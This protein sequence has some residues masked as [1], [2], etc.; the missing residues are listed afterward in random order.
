MDVE[1]LP[2][3]IEVSQVSGN[4]VVTLSG[5]AEGASIEELGKALA[6]VHEQ[7][8]GSAREVVVDLRALE[9]AT[10]S[11]IKAFVTWLQ[12]IHELEPEVRYLAVFVSTKRHPWQE[13]SL[14]ALKAFAGDAMTV[15]DEL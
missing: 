5:A 15:R 3:Q 7:A 4:V 11:S 2:L 14:R 9:F 8:V 6:H 10:S 12:S 13:R 1:E